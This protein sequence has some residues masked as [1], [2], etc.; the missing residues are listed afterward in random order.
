MTPEELYAAFE[1]HSETD[2]LKFD[3]VVAN[4]V[5]RADL[6]AFML[7][8]E[9][10]PGTRDIVSLAGHDEIWLGVSTERLAAVATDDI[11]LELVRCGVR[12]DNDVDLLAMFV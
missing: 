7:L 8:N 10:V 4:A 5:D 1:R 9:L 11:V 6:H 12:Y 2:F 3:R